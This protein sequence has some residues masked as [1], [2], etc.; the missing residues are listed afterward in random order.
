MVK[1]MKWILVSAVIIFSFSFLFSF[2][3]KKEVLDFSGLSNSIYEYYSIDIDGQEISLSEYKNKKILIVNVASKC[4]YT[5]Q[6]E[7]L[8]NLHEKYGDKIEILAFPA[9]DFLWQ[10]P[11]KNEDIKQFCSTKYGVSFRMFEKTVVKKNKKQHPIYKWLSHKE[12]NGWNDQ[13][14]NWNFCKY[15]INEKGELVH[16]Y[17]SKTKPL[18]DEILNFIIE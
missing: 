4:G 12:L 2:F 16:F 14:P 1:Y 6:Y 5:P 17:S 10:E 15:L 13:E 18:S 11:G 3:S 8:Q 9:N 7:G